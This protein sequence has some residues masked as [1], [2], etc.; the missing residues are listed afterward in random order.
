MYKVRVEGRMIAPNEHKR[1]DGHG[2]GSSAKVH[3]D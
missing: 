3:S 2:S 1:T